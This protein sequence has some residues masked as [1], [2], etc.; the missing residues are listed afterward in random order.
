MLYNTASSVNAQFTTVIIVIFVWWQSIFKKR[1]KLSTRITITTNGVE[2]HIFCVKVKL[3]LWYYCYVY[4]IITSTHGW[5]TIVVIVRHRL[6]IVLL[7]VYNILCILYFLRINYKKKYL[8]TKISYKLPVSQRNYTI[9]M[10]EILYYNIFFIF[11]IFL[12]Q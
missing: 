2:A 4:D 1:E 9:E 12:V 11:F 7:S 5:M 6:S 3:S 8:Q 10:I